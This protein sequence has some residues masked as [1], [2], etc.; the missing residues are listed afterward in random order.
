M[1]TTV[2]D[3]N[4]SPLNVI[5]SKGPRQLVTAGWNTLAST[6]LMETRHYQCLQRGADTFAK[7]QMRVITQGLIFYGL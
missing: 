5:S 2:V 7:K 6:G 1:D 3:C 4:N